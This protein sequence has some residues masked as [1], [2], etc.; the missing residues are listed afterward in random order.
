MVVL[1]FGLDSVRWLIAGEFVIGSDRGFLHGSLFHRFLSLL[2]LL[3]LLLLGRGHRLFCVFYLHLLINL[4]LQLFPLLIH[5]IDLQIVLKLVLFDAVQFHVGILDGFFGFHQVLVDLLLLLLLVVDLLIKLLSLIPQILQLLLYFGIDLSDFIQFDVLVL[6]LVINVHLDEFD[7]LLLLSQDLLDVEQ[8]LLVLL[9]RDRGLI[10]HF[11]YKEL[12]VTH[13][14]DVA[15]LRVPKIVL[16]VGPGL[17]QIHFAAGEPTVLTKVHVLGGF[18]GLSAN[19]AFTRA[20]LLFVRN[21]LLAA[22]P[23]QTEQ[24]LLLVELELDPID[25]EE[26]ARVEKILIWVL[27]VDIGQALFKS[28]SERVFVEGHVL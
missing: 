18:K 9:D 24:S 5:V 7:L 8:L 27:S 16:G 17:V 11:L 22:W 19:I 14:A 28:R 2:L 23:L 3:F 10:D 21:D 1:G 6:G 26:L 4:R 25:E 13:L 20:I 12:A 15:P